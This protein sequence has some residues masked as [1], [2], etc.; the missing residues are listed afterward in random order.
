MSSAVRSTCLAKVVWRLRSVEP[1]LHVVVKRRL[2]DIHPEVFAE[3]P[4][5]P[6]AFKCFPPQCRQSWGRI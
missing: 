2:L 5:A 4:G 6:F 1:L 3:Q